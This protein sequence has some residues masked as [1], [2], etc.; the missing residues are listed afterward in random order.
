MTSGCVFHF[1]EIDADMQ[2]ARED[3]LMSH[4]ES[5]F[6][7]GFL[8]ANKYILKHERLF[9]KDFMMHLI[10]RKLYKLLRN[11]TLIYDVILAL[12]AD[13]EKYIKYW[14]TKH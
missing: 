14:N 9:K 13:L 8:L 5:L 10:I 6:E 12:D 2:A 11:H 1:N 7:E 3:L 4:A